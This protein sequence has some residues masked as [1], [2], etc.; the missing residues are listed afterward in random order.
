MTEA[1]LS[2]ETATH[3]TTTRLEKSKKGK[4]FSSI[5]AVKT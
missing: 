2:S 4:G 3:F 1:V 5:A